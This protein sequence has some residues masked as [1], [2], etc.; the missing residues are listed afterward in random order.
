MVATLAGSSQTYRSHPTK[1]EAQFNADKA[2]CQNEAIRN[3]QPTVAAPVAPVYTP[4]T[5]YS[6]NCY[7]MGTAVNCTTTAQP[8]Y[9]GQ[10]QQQNAQNMAQTG[11]N[12][13]TAIAR[14]TYAENCMVNLGWSKSAIESSQAGKVDLNLPGT[15]ITKKAE[16]LEIMSNLYC[17]NEKHKSAPLEVKYEFDRNFYNLDCGE[18]KIRFVCDFSGDLVDMNPVPAAKKNQS[19]YVT[20][21][22]WTL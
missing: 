12:F 16:I 6:T 22:C 1:S 15:V 7:S 20:P 11:A 9:I 5:Q 4:S 17:K 2:F 13:G 21:V 3:V 10:L 18:R 8:N 19:L 14:G